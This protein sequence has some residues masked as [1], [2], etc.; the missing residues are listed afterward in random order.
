M[1][2]LSIIT[3]N[4]NSGDELLKTVKSYIGILDFVESECLIIDGDSNDNSISTI[5]EVHPKIKIFSEQ[6]RG[7]Y[8]AMN[9]GI[10][11][12]SGK[13][14]WFINSGDL[15][16][17]DPL[18]LNNI[19]I[20]SADDNLIYSDVVISN[21]I[22]IKQEFNTKFLYSRMLNH[23][24]IIYRSD[25]F[26]SYDL[27]YGLS[28]DFAHLLSKYKFVR[29]IKSPCP[30]IQYDLNGISSQFS[31]K[32]RSKIWLQ[33]SRAFLYSSLPLHSII[34]G[35]L[36]SLSVAIIK[37]LLPNAFSRVQKLKNANKNSN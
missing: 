5:L 37:L 3:V 19:L 22:F 24:N 4:Y 7:V 33:R 29:A 32:I 12:A 1:T 27:S 18:V 35:T 20:S 30:F 14:L 11:K 26:G 13:W 31:P 10:S 25:L 15:V 34:L 8:D 23:Q 9:K 21:N 17:I 28:A 6:D 16:L 36:I 2:L